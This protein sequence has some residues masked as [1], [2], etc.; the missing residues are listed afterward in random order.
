MLLKTV[1]LKHSIVADVQ[2]ACLGAIDQ[3]EMS[4]VPSRSTSSS[5]RIRGEN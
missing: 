3:A 5:N 1:E 2:P 4:S